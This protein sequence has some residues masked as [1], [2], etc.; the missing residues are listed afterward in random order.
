MLKALFVFLLLGMA[1]LYAQTIPLRHFT[2]EDG[3]I[4]NVIYS[5]CRDSHGYLWFASDNGICRFNG[6]EFKNFTTTEGLP[7]NEVFNLTED[8]E[9][10]LWLCSF[11][12][13]M[14]YYKDDKF[15]T[16]AN[17]PWLKLP[18][19]QPILRSFAHP[20][21]SVSFI[22]SDDNKFVNVHHNTLKVYKNLPSPISIFNKH[23][24]LLAVKKLTPRKYRLLYTPGTVDVD[25]MGKV[26]HIVRYE[27]Q[28]EFHYQNGDIIH[29]APEFLLSKN[30][31]YDMERK[32]LF[33]LR[34]KLNFTYSIATKVVGKNYFV[35][36]LNGLEPVDS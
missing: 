11:N 23:S 15:F 29:G 16:P 32:M 21:S 8:L 14:C 30:G 5:F 35:G 31:I 6:I 34:A 13:T 18:F 22:F 19:K 2:D 9:G 20:D 17:T 4:S 36:L 26:L 10:R 28:K 7:D 3:L 12:G 1:S 24:V 27:D 33:P 25:T